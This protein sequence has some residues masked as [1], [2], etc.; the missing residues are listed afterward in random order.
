[1]TRASGSTGPS[2]AG[3]GPVPSLNENELVV[4]GSAAE[5]DT[6]AV[7]AARLG[8]NPKSVNKMAYRAAR[9]LGARN[10]THAV[11]LACQAGI[12]DGRPR[13]HGDHAGYAAHVAR[14]EE[15]CE[16]CWIGERAYRTERRRARKAAETAKADAA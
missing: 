6:Y 4:L 2:P 14:K 13:R 8:W 15:P 5:G 11:F 9:K 7:I 12:L 16:A 10:I 1:M 3:G